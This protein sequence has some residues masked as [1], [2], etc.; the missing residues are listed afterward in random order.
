MLL[1]LRALLVLL[2]LKV[3]LVL[4]DLF[5][6]QFI[7]LHGIIEQLYPHMFNGLPYQYLK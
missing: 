7:V 4:Q 5:I 1:V 6:Q 2:D 3:L